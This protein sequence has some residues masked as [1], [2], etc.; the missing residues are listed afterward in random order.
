MGVIQSM[1]ESHYHNKSVRNSIKS[2]IFQYN[3]LTVYT[4]NVNVVKYKKYK[5]ILYV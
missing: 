4:L 1:P 3:I 2:Y 5:Y